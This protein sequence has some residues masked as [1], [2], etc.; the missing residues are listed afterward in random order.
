MLPRHSRTL[1]AF[2]FSLCSIKRERERETNVS[3]SNRDGGQT[4]ERV[5]LALTRKQKGI[6]NSC[7]RISLSMS[8]DSSLDPPLSSEVRASASMHAVETKTLLKAAH[9]TETGQQVSAGE[10]LSACRKNS[11]LCSHIFFSHD[12]ARTSF[13]A[14][15]PSLPLVWYI[16]IHP[17]NPSLSLSPFYLKKVGF[18]CVMQHPSHPHAHHYP[19]MQQQTFCHLWILVW[20][21]VG[22][23]MGPIVCHRLRRFPLDL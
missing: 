12:F 21:L 2:F 11:C 4:G 3:S 14:S 7:Q 15:P 8:D 6:R 19:R 16:S 5:W 18:F 23:D 17:S 13:S 9:T 22:T 20:A 10:K 1:F